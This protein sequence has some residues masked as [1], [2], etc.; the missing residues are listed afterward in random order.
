M[1]TIKDELGKWKK[2]KGYKDS[3][4]KQKNR[5]GKKKSPSHSK[6]KLSERDIKEL[7][8]MSRSTYERRRGAIRQK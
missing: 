3:K 5:S 2:A 8:G 6:E 4:P 1:G 7:M